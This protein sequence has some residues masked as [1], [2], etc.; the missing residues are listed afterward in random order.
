MCELGC[1][2]NA[3]PGLILKHT[4]H[5]GLKFIKSLFVFLTC[6]LFIGEL[7]AYTTLSFYIY[8]INRI[9]MSTIWVFSNHHEYCLCWLSHCEFNSLSPGS[10]SAV[11]ACRREWWDRGRDVTA[12]RLS[13]CP[14]AAASLMTSRQSAPPRDLARH[15]LTPTT[16]SWV[17][18]VHNMNAYIMQRSRELLVG[19]LLRSQL[20]ILIAK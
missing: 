4:T 17:W 20:Y 18:T 16:S 3:T 7:I 11:P 5:K 15:L 19:T 8:K 1:L 10:C 12:A 13:Q 14:F 2:E 6:M 9:K